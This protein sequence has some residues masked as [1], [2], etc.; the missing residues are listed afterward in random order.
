M[1]LL[2]WPMAKPILEQKK[3]NKEEHEFYL[4]FAE[5]HFLG[6]YDSVYSYKAV[7]L[8]K[9]KEINFSKYQDAVLLIVNVASF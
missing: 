4:S 1:N 9:Q 6:I 3:N 5:N 8:F 2:T 7:D